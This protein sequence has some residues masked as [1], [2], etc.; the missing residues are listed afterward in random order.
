MEKAR[1]K[2]GYTVAS[3]NTVL[4]G[5]G[6]PPQ[7]TNAR[8]LSPQPGIGYE[9]Y[10]GKGACVFGELLPDRVT[11]EVAGVRVEGGCREG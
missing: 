11:V 4:D 9:A 10:A 3:I 2:G 7:D 1:S 8:S 6:L 5:L